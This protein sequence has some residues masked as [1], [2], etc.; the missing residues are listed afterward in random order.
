MNPDP[1]S[2]PLIHAKEKKGKTP[3]KHWREDKGL[4]EFLHS[5]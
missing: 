1:L 5:L 4:M 2:M 3:E